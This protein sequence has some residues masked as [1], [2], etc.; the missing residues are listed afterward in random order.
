MH[1]Q[2][3]KSVPAYIRTRTRW[4]GVYLAAAVAREGGSAR[5]LGGRGGAG[6]GGAGS[7]LDKALVSFDE[8]AGHRRTS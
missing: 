6:R 1:V 4:L 8:G 7:K 3:R 2:T 5:G